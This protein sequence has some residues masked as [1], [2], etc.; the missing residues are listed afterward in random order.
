LIRKYYKEG[1]HMADCC[2]MMKRMMGCG[3]G[4]QT[5]R[6]KTQS[7]EENPERIRKPLR[8]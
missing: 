1:G 3:E 7:E 5:T 6:K 2:S 4:K 8:P